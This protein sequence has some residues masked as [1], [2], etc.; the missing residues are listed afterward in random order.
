MLVKEFLAGFDGLDS[1]V[2]VFRDDARQEIARG[3]LRGILQAIKL[4]QLNRDY[5]LTRL[6]DMELQGDAYEY[7]FPYEYLTLYV[8]RW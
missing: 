7:S 2:V 6:L 5:T 4:P 8:G 1:T 3:H